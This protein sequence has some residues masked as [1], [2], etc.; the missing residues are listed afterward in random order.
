MAGD[1]RV[2]VSIVIVNWNT[3]D[4]LRDCLRTVY[5]QT[6]GVTFEV[7]VIDNASSDGSVEMIRGEF[8]QAVLI[9]NENN[10]G[11]AAA[12]NQGM[13]IAKGRY[14]LLLNSDTLVLDGA[15]QKTVSFADGRP[16]VGVLGCRV[17]NQ[18]RTLQ[19]TCFMFPSVLNLLLF[20]TYT[21]K[22]FRR[23][24]F[25]GRERMSWWN[26]DDERDVE[27]V[28]GCFMLVRHKAIDEVG[29]MD[30]GFFMY[31]EETDWCFR[32][33]KAGW[34]V[35]FTPCAQIVHLGGASSRRAAGEMTLQLKAG[36]LQFM[37]KHGTRLEYACACLLMGAF[38]ALRI[39]FWVVRAAVC[40]RDRRRSW[41]YACA[42]GRGLA[43]LTRGWRGL[44]G[45]AGLKR[46]DGPKA[47]HGAS[48]LSGGA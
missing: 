28:T 33:R 9:A 20:A 36:I 13:E 18:D 25:F 6:S 29:L 38:L 5:E 37:D 4:I 44:R 45:R 14:V 47:A 12:N 3:R 27:V 22:L 8:P 41:S 48:Q 40:P 11:F 24:R 19:R 26:R 2:D 1:N 42:Y 35:L 39:P 23:S 15:I 7:I 34:G 17:L 21:N 46:N 30:D 32:F 10:R 31:G 43:R 16:E